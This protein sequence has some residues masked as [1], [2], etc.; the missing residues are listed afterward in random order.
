MR[1]QVLKNTKNM[2]IFVVCF[3][4]SKHYI[5]LNPPIAL[6]FENIFGNFLQILMNIRSLQFALPFKV[7]G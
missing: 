1:I 6:K 2:L 4:I 3:E 5:L 7:C